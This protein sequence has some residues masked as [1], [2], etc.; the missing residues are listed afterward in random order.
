MVRKDVKLG[1]AIGGVLL[2]VVVV[3]ALVGTGSKTNENPGAGIVT[4]DTAGP[5]GT[6]STSPKPNEVAKPADPAP[7]PSIADAPKPTHDATSG[8]S[9]V[10][11]EKPPTTPPPIART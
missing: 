11:A 3:Y 6:A 10:A 5:G 9:S 8:G 4:E 1:L 7:S 2:A